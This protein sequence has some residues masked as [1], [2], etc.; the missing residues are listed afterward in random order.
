MSRGGDLELSW[1]E[2]R[3]LRASSKDLLFFDGRKLGEV[4]GSLTFLLWK[5]F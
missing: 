2:N 3:D 4:N 5:T 1:A